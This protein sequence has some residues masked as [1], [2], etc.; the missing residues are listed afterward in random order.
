MAKEDSRKMAS[1]DTIGI[2]S[3][4]DSYLWA[5]VTIRSSL[6]A[7]QRLNEQISE[8]FTFL[9][10]KEALQIVR[11]NLTAEHQK[12]SE[13]VKKIREIADK[14][15]LKNVYLSLDCKDEY[16]KIFYDGCVRI[17]SENIILD[18]SLVYTVALFEDFLQKV[19]QISFKKKPEILMTSQRNLTYEELLRFNDI[20]DARS[21]MIEKEIMVVDED[22]E[23]VRKY[24][25]QKFGIEI[26]EFVNW[27]E[28]K[29][30]FYR[31]NILIHNSGMPNRLY[32]LKTGYKGEN[33][34]LTVSKDYLTDTINLF[35][36]MSLRVGLAFETKMEKGSK[37]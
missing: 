9:N 4:K 27:K 19:F 11:K 14:E 21:A 7:I 25:K 29:E 10:K 12:I 23:Y 3:E 31:R 36:L 6:G 24:I 16:E 1:K 15:N 18:M 13:R 2:V 5:I 30:R 8:F 37:H 17:M 20:N 35:I 26:S 22:I 28:F 34:R 32:R 33:K